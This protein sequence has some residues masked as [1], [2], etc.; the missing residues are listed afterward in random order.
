[1]CPH[2]T[3]CVSSYCYMCVSYCYIRFLILLY[4]CPHTAMY[5]SSYCYVCVLI[6]LYMCVS[7]CYIRVLILPYTCLHTAISMLLQ[8]AAALALAWRLDGLR[9]HGRRWKV[10]L[11]APRDHK[12]V[13]KKK[14]VLYSI[15]LLYWYKGTK[16]E[17]EDAG[18]NKNCCN[19]FSCFTGT[20]VQ[21]LTQIAQCAKTFLSSVF[22]S[23]LISRQNLS[24]LSNKVPHS[25]YLYTI[26]IN[27]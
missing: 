11:P 6:L 24:E 17:A 5:V 1:M 16:I 4:M 23:P 8:T 9:L 19:Q 10:A 18:R 2:T 12:Q 15:Y 21:I 25:Y 27:I 3:T 14:E 26:C 13:G 22:S 7:Y 20:K